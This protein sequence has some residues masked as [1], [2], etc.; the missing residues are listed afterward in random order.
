MHFCPVTTVRSERK[1]KYQYCQN[2]ATFYDKWDLI[3]SKERMQIAHALVSLLHRTLQADL[4]PM[5]HYLLY[6]NS[7]NIIRVSL[8][9][10]DSLRLGLRNWTAKQVF[11]CQKNIS[12]GGICA[13]GTHA[14]CS[15]S[16][17]IEVMFCTI[18]LSGACAE[19]CQVK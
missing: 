15:Y 6:K 14:H 2:V 16:A 18:V 4:A 19:R 12:P 9:G 17:W 11:A 13:I 10:V 7:L 3:H 8:L 5:P 1:V